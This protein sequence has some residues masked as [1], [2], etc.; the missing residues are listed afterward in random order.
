MEKADELK[1]IRTL[2]MLQV[3]SLAGKL[4]DKRD[5]RL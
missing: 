5:P 4:S 1:D 3:L 2:L